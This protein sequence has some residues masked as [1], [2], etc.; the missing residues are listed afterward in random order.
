MDFLKK[1]LI[2]KYKGTVITYVVTGT[3]TF[4]IAKFATAPEWAQGL[5]EGVLK[6]LSDGQITELNPA[7]L[8]AAITPLV[9]SGIQFAINYTQ[10]AAIE[11]QQE[12]N[13]DVVDGW[14]GDDSLK[15]ATIKK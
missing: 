4:I 8:T 2:N 3:V 10:S 5:I 11:K 7:T 13:G 9:V 15:S 6:S 12:K 1:K 14:L